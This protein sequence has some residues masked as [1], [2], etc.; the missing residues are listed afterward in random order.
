MDFKIRN[1]TVSVELLPPNGRSADAFYAREI[2]RLTG[3]RLI[4]KRGVRKLFNRLEVYFPALRPMWFGRPGI[5]YHYREKTSYSPAPQ[6]IMR[7]Y[8]LKRDVLYWIVRNWSILEMED[9]HIT[10]SN[11]NE[12]RSAIRRTKSCLNNREKYNQQIESSIQQL[13]ELR[14]EEYLQ[15]LS[16]YEREL[17]LWKSSHAE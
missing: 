7:E 4:R 8:Y 17:R 11:L 6:Q 16:E 14:R 10:V 3:Y 15:K 1:K 5:E 9:L 2:K 13:V 12:A